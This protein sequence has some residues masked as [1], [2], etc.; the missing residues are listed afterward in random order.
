[1]QNNEF[2]CASCLCGVKQLIWILIF[3]AFTFKIVI[4]SI[5]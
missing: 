3:G 1:M 5:V 2:E 4:I